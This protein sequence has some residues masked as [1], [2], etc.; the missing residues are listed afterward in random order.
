MDLI[1]TSRTP[2]EVKSEWKKRH[3][4][5][6]VIWGALW[7]A[8]AGAVVTRRV[9]IVLGMFALLTI[10]WFAAYLGPYWNCPKCESR[11]W[12]KDPSFCPRCGTALN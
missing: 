8:L 9:E 12:E 4:V 3:T 11:I 10:T 2:D 7:V 5:T 6:K 1:L